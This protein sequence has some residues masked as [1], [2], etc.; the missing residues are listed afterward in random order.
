M[1]GQLDINTSSNAEESEVKYTNN[2]SRSAVYGLERMIGFTGLVTGYL[3][4]SANPFDYLLP[5]SKKQIEFENKDYVYN[6]GEQIKKY[7]FE[8]ITKSRQDMDRMY[9][10]TKGSQFASEAVF[11][12]VTALNPYS[13]MLN[14][15]GNIATEKLA[16]SVIANGFVNAS[17]EAVVKI[18]SSALM[19]GVTNGIENTFIE[20]SVN[21]GL[22]GK[23]LSLKDKA[24][25]FA[26]G[27]ASGI[28]FDLGL[29]MI[30]KGI[31]FGS[32][33]TIDNMRNVKSWYDDLE[34]NEKNKV[35]KELI[36]KID[37]YIPD[38][39]AKVTTTTKEFINDYTELSKEDTVKVLK[40]II[41]EDTNTDSI[42]NRIE[43]E[44]FGN[45]E[46]SIQ[47]FNIKEKSLAET[48]IDEDENLED[49]YTKTY[50][51]KIQ[52]KE[53]NYIKKIDLSSEA[54]EFLKNT[55][56][57]DLN[58][59]MDSNTILV[60]NAIEKKDL[61]DKY[62]KSIYENQ[63]LED[64][65]IKN[66][67]DYDYVKEHLK[68]S[69]SLESDIIARIEEIDKENEYANNFINEINDKIGGEYTAHNLLEELNSHKSIVDN[70]D[71]DLLFKSLNEEEYSTRIDQNE[72]KK[73]NDRVE[74]HS[75]NSEEIINSFKENE[76]FKANI[77]SKIFVDE[78]D[79]INSLNKIDNDS[80]FQDILKEIKV[81]RIKNI[82]GM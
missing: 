4:Q 72:I 34:V 39:K 69:K 24:K 46:Q 28:G 14:G 77:G 21:L 75:I 32:A 54:K 2:L 59:L 7:S 23:G 9:K 55:N 29:K 51:D 78:E 40:R 80:E 65:M 42:D 68:E 38:E 61:M 17:K 57:N 8:Q 37:E 53:T 31:D 45:G 13:I 66:G 62:M 58:G 47:D 50:V 48:I 81:C 71:E 5:K 30:A 74:E 6:L 11:E 10:E 26:I 18:G 16:T 35:K 36:K 82:G 44:I 15:F 43:K 22:Y 70:I 25:Y 60:S 76:E 41:G 67:F 27:T 3:L 73:T 33:K 12:G 20:N 1:Y 49:L 63:D 64:D 56:S 79:L 19:N 52:G